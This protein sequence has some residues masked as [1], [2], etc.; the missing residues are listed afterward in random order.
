MN[1]KNMLSQLMLIDSYGAVGLA[2]MT[3]AERLASGLRI[4]SSKDDASTIGVLSQ[5]D[6]QIM[7]QR[8]FMQTAED[9]ASFLA[10]QE[11]A[12]NSMNEIQTR[13][14]AIK[15]E[16]DASI[17]LG[18]E[19]SDLEE[20]YKTLQSEFVGITREQFNG[21]ALFASGVTNVV[22]EHTSIDGGRSF[23]MTKYTPVDFE[24][25][26]TFNVGEPY[27]VYSLISHAINKITWEGAKADAESR[28]GHLAVI[29]SEEENNEVR[30]VVDNAWNT[31]I[32]MQKQPGANWESVTG[33]EVTY[34]NWV[35]E[36]MDPTVSFAAKIRPDG[37]WD[38]NIDASSTKGMYYVLEIENIYGF[39]DF[40]V[41]EV[42]SN[43]QNIAQAIA[44]NGSEQNRV[45]RVQK[46]TETNMQN[47]GGIVARWEE[48]DYAEESAKNTAQGILMES[49]LALLSQAN[50]RSQSMLRLLYGRIDKEWDYA[51]PSKSWPLVE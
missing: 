6:A 35:T 29:T 24:L 27:S 1:I 11:E 14:L 30:G 4:N 38:G 42:K 7:E 19:I 37:R 41:N 34:T 26:K 15:E 5:I 13:M 49:S 22:Q 3:T 47:L 44:Q 50:I 12:L 16:A 28:G 39:S 10:T 21:V 9:A 33:E 46:I 32:G 48:A 17:A 31:W 25:G 2:R 18:E 8:A 40:G 23:Q 36:G 43:L 45:S 51:A 20:E